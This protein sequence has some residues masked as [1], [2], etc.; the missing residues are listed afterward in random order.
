M[1]KF[2]RLKTAERALLL[3]AVFG[4]MAARIMLLV[5]PLPGVRRV[6]WRMLSAAS[7][8]APGHCCPAERVTWAVAVAA[9]WS[10]FGS[11][12]L[13]A[14]LVGQALLSR[15]GHPARLRIGVRREQDRTFAAHAWLE[16]EGKVVVGGPASVIDRYKP[17]PE[18]EHLIR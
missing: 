6:V 10:P 5:A 17:L 11:T 16:S 7:A 8:L 18:L 13:A 12:C 3:R 1:R 15:H 9:K 2:L 4:V 14:A